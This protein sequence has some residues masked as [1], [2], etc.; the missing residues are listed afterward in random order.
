MYSISHS[1][2]IVDKVKL[3][4]LVLRERLP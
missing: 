2:Y 3:G 4:Q 1:Y